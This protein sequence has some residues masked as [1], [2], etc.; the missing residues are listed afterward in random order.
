[1]WWWFATLASADPCPDPTVAVQAAYDAFDEA[2]VDLAQARVDEALAGLLCAPTPTPANV[3]EDLY[4]FAAVVA[5]ARGD[6]RA[7]VTALM[8][9]R[10]AFPSGAPH[11]QFGPELIE[12]A[13]AWSERLAAEQVAVVPTEISVVVDGVR[14]AVGQRH[15]VP[16]GDHLLQAE[17]VTGAWTSIRQDVGVDR[18]LALVDVPAVASVEPR[19]GREPKPPRDPRP[20]PDRIELPPKHRAA[21]LVSGA[22]SLAAGA[23]A[24]GYG[25]A[26]ER[27]FLDDA[28]DQASFGGC[29][30]GDACYEDARIEAIRGDALAVRIAYIAG[31]GLSALGVGLLGTELFILPAPTATGATVGLRGRF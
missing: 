10:A 27:R 15:S 4:G 26:Q 23:G 13:A 30:I 14:L 29:A 16:M 1:M 2:E 31:Y 5:Y 20:R 6:Q 22:V 24:L 28:Y 11:S 19:P 7:T 18:S 8:R 9:L 21:L 17:G 12:Q 3:L 25:L